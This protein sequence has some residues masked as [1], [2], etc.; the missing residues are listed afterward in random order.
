M[1]CVDQLRSPDFPA[2]RYDCANGRFWEI[3]LKATAR[4]ILS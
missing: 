4:C 2:L 1:C 3:L